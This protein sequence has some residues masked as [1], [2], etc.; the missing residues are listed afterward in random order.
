MVATVRC[1]SGFNP[2]AHNKS[3]P[4]GGS[5]GISQFQWNTFYKNAKFENPD[6]TD[7][8]QQLETMA[9]M[10][11]RGQ[12]GQWSCWWKYLGKPVPWQ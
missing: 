4:N 9:Q 8:R 1:E 7:S 5:Y 12:Q 11:A 6:I 2:N 10:W 3:D